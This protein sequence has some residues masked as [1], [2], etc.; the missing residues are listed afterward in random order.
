[1]SKWLVERKLS[2]AAERL[3]QLRAELS[4]VDEQL[5]FLADAADDAR[6]RAMVSETPMA[7]KEHREAQKHADAMTRHRSQLVSQIG[8]LEKAQDELLERLFAEI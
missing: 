3:R 5:A 7:D 4:V 8:E 6:M 1:M 2:E